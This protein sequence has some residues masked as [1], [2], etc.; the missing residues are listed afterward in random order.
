MS[1]GETTAR[2]KKGKSKQ[3]PIKKGSRVKTTRKKLWPILKAQEHQ[4][5]VV[6]FPDN[7]QLYGTVVGGKVATGFT[8]RFDIMPAGMKDINVGRKRVDVVVAG[9]EE[10]A[11]ARADDAE[12]Y[13]TMEAPSEAAKKKKDPTPWKLSEEKFLALPIED[14]KVIHSYDMGIDKEGTVIKWKIFG[15]LEYV[16]DVD[17]KM[18]YPEGPYTPARR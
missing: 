10:P 6:S 16:K 12:R 5:A 7:Y 3:P 1:Q 15:D 14:R 9:E 11:F 4:D 17:D 2:K 8:V 13:A 18:V